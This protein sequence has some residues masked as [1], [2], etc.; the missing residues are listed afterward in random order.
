MG[1]QPRKK[2]RA[3]TADAVLHEVL[4]GKLV[5]GTLSQ[6]ATYSDLFGKMSDAVLLLDCASFRVL[7]ANPAAGQVFVSQE[8]EL[9]GESLGRWVRE[10]HRRGLEERLQEAA[11]AHRPVGPFDVELAGESI[12][13]LSACRL[14][15][16]DY[17]EVIQVVAKDVS[18]ARRNQRALE[19]LTLKLE[20]LSK[21]DEMTGLSNFRSFMG[22]LMRED[23][24]ARRYSSTYSVIFCDVD[25]FKKYNDRNGHP[26]GDEVLRGVARLLRQHC[27]KSDFAARYGG[28]EFVILCPGV[29]AEQAMH[30]A[31]RV[32]AA[33]EAEVFA[34]REAQPLGVVSISV[35]VAGFPEAG[36][37]H[38]EVLKHADQALYAS[39]SG[40]RNR[41]SL[42]IRNR[43]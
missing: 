20:R 2:P 15:L 18:E 14:R 13:E 30:L 3:K 11:K 38:Q 36:E 32:R 9:V 37:G 16:A 25:H 17:C 31:E 28:E 26:A 35:G 21:T 6:L 22:D 7:E 4:G 33:V 23:E 40:G 19:E 39:K 10:S 43:S 8:L 29:S 41:V 24:R 12:L 34:H 27:R 5:G 42:Y 1:S